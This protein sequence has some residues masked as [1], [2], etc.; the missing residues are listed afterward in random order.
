MLA[1][2]ILF[3]QNGY[4]QT[5]TA[6]IAREAGTSES[7]LVRYFGGKAGVLEAI[8]NESWG[9]LHQKIQERVISAPTAKEALLRILS[10]LVETFQQDPDLGH[11]F[12]FEGRRIRGAD[13]EV[14]ISEGFR[15]FN[16]LLLQ[17]FERGRLDGS[18]TT[19]L[20]PAA[21]LSGLVGAAEGIIRDRMVADRLGEPQPFSDEDVRAVI[22]SFLD[23]LG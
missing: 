6:S 22:G 5:S 9:A 13:H 3:A 19:T 15:K 14:F 18:I 23:A 7:Q 17:L 16:L 10:E 8:F 12:L 2:K 11:I 20:N 4:E 1:S 21:L